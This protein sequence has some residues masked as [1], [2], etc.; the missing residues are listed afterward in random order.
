MHLPALNNLETALTASVAAADTEVE[1]VTTAGWPTPGIVSV[2]KEIIFYTGKTG[3]E[4]TG[5]TRGFDGTLTPALHTLIDPAT[6]FDRLVQ[7]RI[8]AKHIID[9][10]DMENL[11]LTAGRNKK[12]TSSYLRGPDG[13]PQNQAGFVIPFDYTIVGL[14]MATDGAFAWTVE[15]RKN[16]AVG[17]VASLT[18]AAPASKKF[19]GALSVDVDAGDELQLFADGI[20]IPKPTVTLTLRRR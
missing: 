20:Q 14:G 11:V 13:T 9:L 7:L 2:G 12:H 10:Q 17:V 6:G 5:L 4:F 1:V 16:N 8:I 19:D 15:V 18:I 3:T